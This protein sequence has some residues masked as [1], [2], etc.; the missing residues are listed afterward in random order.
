MSEYGLRDDECIWVDRRILP[1]GGAFGTHQH[2]MVQLVWA[3]RGQVEVVSGHSHLVLAPSHGLWIPGGHQ[4]DL[5]GMAGSE[6]YCVYLWEEEVEVPWAGPTVLSINAVARALV[7][8]LAR[9]DLRDLDAR[10]ARATLLS[11]LAPAEAES[12]D[13]PMP[14]DERARRLARAVLA[15]PQRP[16]DLRGWASRLHTSEKTIQRAFDEGTGMSYS[17]WRTHARLLS[18]LRLLAEHVPVT[19]VASRCGYSSVNGFTKA[20]R[21]H[22]G[23]TPGEY[24]R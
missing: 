24:F 11:V 13:L 18:S 8:H 2:P 10:H 21:H 9:E 14:N 12:V 1:R 15:D 5:R 6:V 19:T 23:T 20:F 22:F 4:H 7:P 17:R 16:H 3:E